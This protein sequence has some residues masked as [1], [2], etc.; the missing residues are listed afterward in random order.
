MEEI[1]GHV[2]SDSTTYKFNGAVEG[3]A[4]PVIPHYVQVAR[5]DGFLEIESVVTLFIK[6]WI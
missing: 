6:N 5:S 1:R 4:L 3:L 2:L